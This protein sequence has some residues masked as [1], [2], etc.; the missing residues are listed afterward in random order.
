M[1]TGA[2][3]P[4]LGIYDSPLSGASSSEPMQQLLSQAAGRRGHCEGRPAVDAESEPSVATGDLCSLVPAHSDSAGQSSGSSRD[5]AAPFQV[6]AKHNTQQEPAGAV[7]MQALR[8]QPSKQADRSLR[9]KRQS[10]WTAQHG[11][12]WSPMGKLCRRTIMQSKPPNAAAASHF[13]RGTVQSEPTAAAPQVRIATA[14]K[15]TTQVTGKRSKKARKAARKATGFTSSSAHQL[16][17]RFGAAR[18]SCQ[19]AST[20][21]VEGQDSVAKPAET[22][23]WAA[24]AHRPSQEALPTLL[25]MLDIAQHVD[26]AAKAQLA[27]HNL[28]GSSK[29]GS[30]VCNG[31]KVEEG[32]LSAQMSGASSADACADLSNHGIA[33]DTSV[34]STAADAEGCEGHVSSTATSPDS[35]ATEACLPPLP[36]GAHPA[37]Q[38]LDAAVRHVQAALASSGV[39]V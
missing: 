5:A 26:S 4:V 36:A 33:A 22:L 30:A 13:K 15:G 34:E 18:V 28:S 9:S 19:A 32:Q 31:C 8:K 1:A 11:T 7:V 37:V 29:S 2:K 17:T 25:M 20:G 35:Q 24:E 39:V 16:E 38:H 14:V 12:P 3:H 27:H 6:E 23:E 10:A 21:A